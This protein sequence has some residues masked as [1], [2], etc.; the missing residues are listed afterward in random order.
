MLIPCV[1]AVFKLITSSNLVGCTTGVGRLCPLKNAA[2][3]VAPRLFYRSCLAPA[4]M[5]A[6]TTSSANPIAFMKQQCERFSC[7]FKLVCLFDSSHL[8]HS[9]LCPRQLSP[10]FGVG[11]LMRLLSAIRTALFAFILIRTGLATAAQS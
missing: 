10:E 7:S 8:C 3:C 5:S 2:S 9:G 1:L 6:S 11:L 4:A